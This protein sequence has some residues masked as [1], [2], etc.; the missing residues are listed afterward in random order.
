[1]IVY[2]VAM[3]YIE[4]DHFLGVLYNSFVQAE[5]RLPSNGTEEKYFFDES[6]HL[7]ATQI[8]DYRI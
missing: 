2:P 6:G 4:L 7:V 1:M 8:A 5:M 3:K